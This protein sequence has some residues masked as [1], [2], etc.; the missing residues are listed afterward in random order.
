MELIFL[1]L[2]WLLKV[3]IRSVPSNILIYSFLCNRITR[4]KIITTMNRFDHSACFTD[5]MGMLFI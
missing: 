4:Q 1:V 3:L 5:N 2:Q